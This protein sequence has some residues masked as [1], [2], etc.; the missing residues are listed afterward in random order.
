MNRITER[1]PSSLPGPSP[2]RSSSQEWQ[3]ATLGICQSSEISSTAES[4]VP[5]GRVRRLI[6]CLCFLVLVAQGLNLSLTPSL[7]FEDF[8]DEEEGVIAVH[9][10]HEH[11]G[12][13]GENGNTSMQM[14][15]EPLLSLETEDKDTVHVKGEVNNAEN[16]TN[17]DGAE[18]PMMSTPTSL[19]S[20]VKTEEE[21]TNEE[22]VVI[23]TN[24]TSLS[25]YKN[26]TVLDTPSPS[27]APIAA[28]RTL[29]PTPAVRTKV[30][31]VP[32][33]L[34]SSISAKEAP[35]INSLPAPSLSADN[36]ETSSS[37]SAPFT[38]RWCELRGVDWYPVDTKSWQLRAPYML[39]PGAKHAGTSALA[40][41]LVSHPNVRSPS[42]SNELHFFLQRSFGQ[43][44]VTRKEQRTLVMP[45]RE[46]MYARDYPVNE[47]KTNTDLV[48][49][50]AS[51]SYL[52]YSNLLPRRILCVMPWV[53]LVV[54]LQNPVDRLYSQ[55]W[56]SRRL[57]LRVTFDN[58]IEQEFD[59]M[60]TVGL[61]GAEE[62]SKR[63]DEEE[64]DEN[65]AWYD[66]QTRSVSGAVGR[67]LYE[68][69][70]QQWI[71]AL[72]AAGRDPSEAVWVVKAEDLADDSRLQHEYD[73]MLRFLKLPDH[74]LSATNRIKVSRSILPVTD[75]NSANIK[76]SM[77]TA[78]RQRLEDFFAPYNERLRELLRSYTITEMN[79][80]TGTSSF[81]DW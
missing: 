37:F 12:L 22:Q 74:Q 40:D 56:E 20:T 30:A 31:P 52:Y 59:L 57:G 64:H 78:T 77:N 72:Q 39:I 27:A 15:S 3:P 51:S 41:L 35:I 32:N 55:Y 71:D 2:C 38:D 49:L 43:R 79:R 69:Q 36:N 46:R 17:Y 61:I 34:P 53:K 9:E 44:Y 76:G 26:F 29:R 42:R 10:Q 60:K 67:S 48:S 23:E 18:V 68:I 4:L 6:I 5:R 70:L 65:A 75:K 63:E 80:T 47:L 19:L 33:S 16:K 45:V 25:A 50:D 1:R 24:T 7:D 58:W 73:S 21:E 11:E 66:Y 54:V 62:S 14:S 13:G 8:E 81:F 28:Q